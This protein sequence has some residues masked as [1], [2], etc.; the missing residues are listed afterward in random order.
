LSVQ[1]TYL[2]TF[3]TL[4]GLGLLLGTFGLAT[5]MLRNVLERQSELALLRAIG[6]RRSSVAE[7]V[8]W[9]NGFI[10]LWGLVAGSVSAILATSPNLLSRGANLPWLSLAMLLIAVFVTGMIAALFAV[11][12][13]SRLPI[14][15][16]LRGE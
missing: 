15:T 16:T 4:G 1:N 8:L 6:F 9:E 3:Q 11:I 14:V 10:L 2:S 7:L 13:A 12:S 5:V